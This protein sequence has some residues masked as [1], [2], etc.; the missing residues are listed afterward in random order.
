MLMVKHV[1]YTLTELGWRQSASCLG[2]THRYINHQLLLEI[3]CW[4]IRSLIL[5]SKAILTF[6]NPTQYFTLDHEMQCI[7][8]LH[9]YIAGLPSYQLWY[10]SILPMHFDWPAEL[11]GHHSRNLTYNHS[12]S[13]SLPDELMAGLDCSHWEP[14]WEN[15][16]EQADLFWKFLVLC[17]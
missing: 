7:Y 1:A 13:F 11:G 12:S 3:E 8:A 14:S 9:G 15:E 17:T 16:S 5:S 4:T 2:G 6:L 10:T